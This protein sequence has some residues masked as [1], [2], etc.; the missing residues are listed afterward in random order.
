MVNRR[1]TSANVLYAFYRQRPGIELDVVT[2]TSADTASVLAEVAAGTLDATFRSL[3]DSGL[4]VPAGL[5]SA[6][7]IDERHEVL[8]G[9]RHPLADA[10]AVT[11]AE[12][13]AHPVWMPGLTE[14][15]PLGYYQDLAAAFG[16]TIHTGGPSFGIES[17][18]AELA[19]SDRLATLVGDGS[20][21]LWPEAY[22]LRRIP[23]VDPAPVYPL[24]VIWRADNSHPVLAQFLDHLRA[25]YRARTGGDVWT[26]QWAR[27]GA[28][29]R[30]AGPAR[31]G[32]ADGWRSRR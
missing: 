23:V 1:I 25:G 30:P 24:S 19:G 12:L 4:A 13:A 5:R 26:P 2:L 8:V 3:R 17:Q 7:V 16:L 22:D 10:A 15:E 11:P 14:V 31:S 28:D 21:Y 32:G 29:P 27:P 9:P 20:R 18:L 6:R